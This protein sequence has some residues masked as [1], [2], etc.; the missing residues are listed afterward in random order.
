MSKSCS[1]GPLWCCDKKPTCRFKRHKRRGFDPWVVKIPWRRKWHPTPVSLP[2][3]FHGQRS[4]EDCSP[5]GCRRVGHDIATKHLLEVDKDAGRGEKSG[6]SQSACHIHP[7][8]GVCF[9]L[10]VTAMLAIQW[11]VSPAPHL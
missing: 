7:G 6:P 3:K 10:E 9:C 1:M 5:W 11:D 4:L 2:G 8:P